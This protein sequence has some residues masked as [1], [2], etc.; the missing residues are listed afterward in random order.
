MQLHTQP[1]DDRTL[2]EGTVDFVSFSYYSSRCITVDK[3]LM[4]AENA[5]GNAVSASVKNPY[6]KV[7]EWGW[8]IDPVGLRVT[9]NTIYDRS[10]KPMFIVENG[11]GGSGYRRA[12]QL[13]PRQL[14]HRLSAGAH[15]RD[16]KGHQR[17]RLPL[18]GYTTGGPSTL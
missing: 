13:H 17:G 4:A 5:E 16:G 8:A 9:L 14:P 6:L 12:G 18:M 3:E 10:E 7:S 11:L 15:R 2:R 1:E